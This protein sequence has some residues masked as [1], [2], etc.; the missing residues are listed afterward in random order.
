MFTEE[1]KALLAKPLSP[2]RIKKRV[3]AGMQ[4]SY[5]EGWDV[6]S[7]ANDI[8]GIDGWSS[9]VTS[10]ACIATDEYKGG[11]RTG[12]QTAYRATVTVVIGDQQHEDAGFG[13]G[14]SYSNAIESHEIALKEAVTDALKR[15]L[16]HWGDQFGLCLYDKQQRG[17]G[18]EDGQPAA[19]EPTPKAPLRRVSQPEGP[20][21]GQQ[22]PPATPADL[23]AATEERIQDYYYYLLQNGVD[24]TAAGTQ[25]ENARVKYNGIIPK[26]WL[27]HMFTQAK[28]KF[29][30]PLTE[31]TGND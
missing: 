4:L 6:I 24:A 8:F 22:E 12:W 25:L 23:E 15:A 17:V 1:Q 30:D 9:T 18:V 29:G 14:I 10:L 27:D 19:K 7:T 11:N 2:D 16:R 13:S 3:Q 26:A 5:L 20:R 31:E 28:L 21:K